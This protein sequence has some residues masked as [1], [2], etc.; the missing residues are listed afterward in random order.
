MYI[1]VRVRVYMCTCTCPTNQIYIHCVFQALR[2]APVRQDCELGPQNEQ[3]N[4]LHVPTCSALV[5]VQY[6]IVN[7]TALVAVVI[8]S[9]EFSRYSLPRNQLTYSRILKKYHF[10][11]KD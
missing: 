11:V 7:F 1:H 4:S 6:K 8:M 10:M 2:D 3:M 5:N 9:R